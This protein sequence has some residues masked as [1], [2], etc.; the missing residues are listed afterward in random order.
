MRK[1]IQVENLTKEFYI[2]KRKKGFLGSIAGLFYREKDIIK[3]VDNISFEI[4]TGEI[5]G[6]L[7]PNGAG[8][9]TTIKMLTGILLPTSGKVMV[10]GMD[11]F[12]NRKVF[13]KKI[14]VVFGQRTQLWW[15][16]PLIESF[17][18]LRLIYKIEKKVFQQRFDEYVELLGMKDFLYQQV[19]KL[20]LGQRMRADLAASLIHEPSIL[21]LDEPTIGLDILTKDIVRKTILNL[22]QKKKITVILTTHDMEDIEYLANRLILIDKGKIYYNGQ[23]E[24]FLE[25]YQTKKKVILTLEK[26][27]IFPDLKNGL[28]IL[29]NQRNRFYEIEI[30]KENSV[31]LVI[32]LVQKEGGKIQDI[33]VKKQELADVLKLI[34]KNQSVEL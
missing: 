33:T 11:P 5:V 30:P 29:K 31:G 16:L 3:A 4:S 34:Y 23:I 18:L 17:D 32:D 9:S 24:T 7:G 2:K 10:N 25:A 8:K 14:G 20:S 22:N 19:R 13:T 12:K 28:K 1:I 21:F 27:F 15:D 26:E 6:Y